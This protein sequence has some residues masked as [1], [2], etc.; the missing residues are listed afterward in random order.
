MTQ[1]VTK[2]K[3]SPGESDRTEENRSLVPYGSP[4]DLGDLGRGRGALTDG[5]GM[6]REVTV[7]GPGRCSGRARKGECHLSLCR[8]QQ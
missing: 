6:L 8:T 3:G 2:C 4:G 7:R 5:T 1:E